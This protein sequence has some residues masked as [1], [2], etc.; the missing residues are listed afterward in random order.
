[1]PRNQIAP[2]RNPK[3]TKRIIWID[4]A[5]IIGLYL[6]IFAH[7]YNS[8]GKDASNIIRTLIYGFHM[9]LFFMI[10]G[11]LWKKRDSLK[12]AIQKNFLS[13]FIPWLIFNVI[14]A[15][16]F[17]FTKH[18]GNLLES[19]LVIPKNVYHGLDGPAHSSWFI[20]VLF[21]IRTL[22]DIVAQYKLEKLAVIVALLVSTAD[23][24][25]NTILG[26]YF[27]PRRFFIASIVIGFTFFGLGKILFHLYNKIETK[28]FILILLSMG[29]IIM[30]CLIT[31]IN[32][33][34]S[35]SSAYMGKSPL[36]F[37]L[38]AILGSSGIIFLS[39]FFNNPKLNR[40]ASTI[41]NAS[42]AI[43]LVH[44]FFV[45]IAKYVKNEFITSKILMFI[46]Y[47]FSSI[48]I[49]IVCVGVYQVTSKKIP[50]IW[51]K[52]NKNKPN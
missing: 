12:E 7:C 25:C 31:S 23:A 52:I 43:V 40:A 51:G 36:L 21:A 38:N 10:S 30:S 22:Y 45:E 13:L 46:L 27:I 47:F 14:I 3:S 26:K 6:V 4:Y 50:W 48:L 44:P 5:K 11:M 24:F 41:S 29:C 37:Y 20:L 8:E 18:N 1:M 42:I 15:T 17:A 9:P 19:L 2:P 16:I 33:K 28:R 35:T 34:I 32:G 49:Y 39:K